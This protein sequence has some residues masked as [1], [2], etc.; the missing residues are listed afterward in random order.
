M[1]VELQIY[2]FFLKHSWVSFVFRRNGSFDY[3]FKGKKIPDY[4][5]SFR[6][7]LIAKDG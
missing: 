7:V 2:G 4:P 3:D 1:F 6:P 5:L